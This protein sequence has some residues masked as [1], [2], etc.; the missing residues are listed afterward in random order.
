LGKQSLVSANVANEA[1]MGELG[2][3]ELKTR[4]DKLRL[5]ML[6]K[7]SELQE[8]DYANVLVQD[9]DSPWRQYTDNLLEKY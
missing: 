7:F 5:K 8:E 6:K 4:R 2:W 3:W 1:I 9:K